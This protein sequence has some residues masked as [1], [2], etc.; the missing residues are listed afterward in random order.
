MIIFSNAGELDLLHPDLSTRS[1][2]T[3][4]G[5]YDDDVYLEYY[6]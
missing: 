1:W 3:Y 2:T 5:T 4:T 6:S